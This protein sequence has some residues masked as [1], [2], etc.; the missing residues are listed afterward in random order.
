MVARTP[1][2]FAYYSDTYTGVTGDSIRAAVDPV[3]THAADLGTLADELKGDEQRILET[4]EGDITTSVAANPHVPYDVA[5]RLGG[6]A[7]F[8]AACTR[9]FALK[10]DAFDTEVNAIN[11]SYRS[12]VFAA[13][14]DPDVRGGDLNLADLQ[15]AFKANLQPRYAAAEEALDTAADDVA[16]KLKKGPTDEEVRQFIRQGLMPLAAAS[17]F[18]TLV[19]T[20]SDKIEA[21]KLIVKDTIAR[22]RDEGLLTGPDPDGYY[23]QWLQNAARRG[24]SIDDIVEIAREHD[25]RPDDFEVLDGLEEVKDR[26]GKS[27]F[28]LPT[29]ISGD[30]ARKAVLMTYILNAGTD[31]GTADSSRDFSETPYSSD[32]IQR[33]KDRQGENN[34]F[35]YGQD[36]GFVNGNGGRLATTPNGML[37]GLGGNGLQDV[38]SSNGGTTFGDIFMLNIDDPD[39]SHEA[40]RSVIQSGVANYADNDGEPRPDSSLDLDRLLHHEERHSQ[41]WAREGYAGFI[42]SYLNESVDWDMEGW[43][44]FQAPIPHTVDGKDNSYEADAGLTDG[45]Y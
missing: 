33:I 5:I 32:E 36:V 39:D 15:S 10:V 25:I 2:P 43:G 45:G 11:E 23:L 42:A 19:L 3:D 38:Y 16:A 21:Y 27:F 26:D 8:A 1:G 20:E 12:Q 35:S 40:I 44:P 34:W 37:M 31:Y 7:Q 28:I 18:P 22:L 9:E 17:F 24:I 30:D 6:K 41:Q 29:D 13:Q 14:H 4:T